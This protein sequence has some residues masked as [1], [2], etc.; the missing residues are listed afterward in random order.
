M[1]SIALFV[2]SLCELVIVVALATWMMTIP[3][4]ERLQFV[5][6]VKNMNDG[7]KRA[8]RDGTDLDISATLKV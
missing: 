5:E 8:R 2:R 4:D 6:F 3:E 7:I 1:K